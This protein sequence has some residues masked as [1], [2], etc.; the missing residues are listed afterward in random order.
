MTRSLALILIGLLLVI[1][2]PAFAQEDTLTCPALAEQAAQSVRTS[3]AMMGE[4]QLCYGHE[5]VTAITSS[6]LDFVSPGMM[7]D[8]GEVELVSTGAFDPENGTWGIAV[9]RLQLDPASMEQTQVLVFG[10]TVLR[11]EA[12]GADGSGFE[13]SVAGGANLRSGPSTQDA[14]VGGLAAGQTVLA[15]GR[16]DDGT[17]LRVQPE[18]GDSGWLFAELATTDEDVMGLDVVTEL[19][20]DSQ[21]SL[22]NVFLNTAGSDLDCAEAQAN[23]ILVQ[24]PPDADPITLVINGAVL[25]LD[26]TVFAQSGDQL[27]IQMLE[28][29]GSILAADETQPLFPGSQVRVPLDDD[30]S[31]ADVP[32]APEAYD[33]DLLHALPLNLLGRSVTIVPALTE[34]ALANIGTCTVTTN[35]NVNLRQGPGTN[36]ALAGNLEADATA[37][38]IGQA[39]GTDQITW[40]QLADASWV[41]SDIV[42]SRE[43]CESV[44]VVE[45][46]SAPAAAQVATIS[47]R[48]DQCGSPGRGIEA[49][50]VVNVY[51]AGGT[52]PTQAE[53]RQNASNHSGTITVNGTALS[54]FAGQHQWGENDWGVK[55]QANWVASSGTHTVI[56]TSTINDGGTCTITVP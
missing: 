52:W 7:A 51:M 5:D 39:L 34:E 31:V 49:G 3:C 33:E 32:G 18:D 35:T 48:I 37:S 8:T 30:G 28:G 23:G 50:D 46:P 47:Y 20:T 56:G 36:F 21:V 17:W 16:S 45:A 22:Q 53:A 9:I 1:V 10:D 40:W 24:S 19:E 27:T 43:G 11:N 25:T 42:T 29:T 12:F 14:I 6:N 13:V 41:R 2:A 38:V 44:P 54:T 15:N 26:G 4:S 55:V